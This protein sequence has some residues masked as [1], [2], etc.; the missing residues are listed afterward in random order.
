MAYMTPAPRGFAGRP[1]TAL[2]FAVATGVMG[3]HLSSYL[4]LSPLSA[5]FI[6][7]AVAGIIHFVWY[8]VDRPKQ[9]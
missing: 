1:L 2:L 6:I 8:W 7:V 5:F 3:Y 9:S 4:Q